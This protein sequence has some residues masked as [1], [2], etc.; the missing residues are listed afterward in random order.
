MGVYDS[1]FVKSKKGEE[2]ELQLKNSED[3][4]MR[5]FQIGDPVPWPDGIIV[6]LEGA[7]VVSGGVLVAAFA[8]E[9]RPF[10]DKWNGHLDGP[11][12]GWPRL[13]KP[14][15]Q[16]TLAIDWMIEQKLTTA[17]RADLLADFYDHYCKK[18]KDK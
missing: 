1:V 4:C 18:I 14:D 3:R 6:C 10:Y 7:V 9:D 17:S 5:V 2:I 16:V 8:E 11:V 15:I 13:I 12:D